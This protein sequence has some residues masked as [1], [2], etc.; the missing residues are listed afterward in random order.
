MLSL[1]GFAS[2]LV[3]NV[4]SQSGCTTTTDY[5]VQFVIDESGSVGPVNYDATVDFVQSMIQNDISDDTPVSVLSFGSK[6]G[7]EPSIGYEIIYRF[8][9]DQTSRNG[10]IDALENSQHE[11]N[12]TPTRT[13][14][15]GAL[16]EWEAAE[17]AGK[18]NNGERILFLITD[19]VPYPSDQTP[20]LQSIY[21]KI[22]EL[23]VRIIILGI[24]QF[25]IATIS[26]VAFR[27]EDIYQ[28]AGFQEAQFDQL[29][30]ELSV[31]SCPPDDGC[32]T[33][34]EY[35]VQIIMDES[36]SVGSDGFDLSVEFVKSLIEDDISATTPISV[37]S[38]GGGNNPDV[39]LI[40]R[41]DDDQTSRNAVL[42]ALDAVDHDAGST[43]TRTAMLTGIEEYKRAINAGD[44]N[45]GERLLFLMTDGV[46]YPSNT[47]DPCISTILDDLA[48]LNIRVII[49]GIGN[50]NVD[51]I[52]CLA[53][54]DDI[55]TTTGF[56]SEA[57]DALEKAIGETICP[58][59][60]E[61]IVSPP[62]PLS[63]QKAQQFCK[64]T[65]GT[66]LATIATDEDRL[67]AIA[68]LGEGE[69]AWIGL[70]THPEQTNW[71][72]RSGE[73][74]PSDSAY[75]CVDFWL[76]QLNENTALRP[77]CIGPTEQG[78]ECA[79]FK[80]TENGVDNDVPSEIELRFLCDN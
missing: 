12:L 32:V 45:N 20:C 28:I 70:Y 51:S 24:G 50:F 9:D 2:L 71:R 4:Y 48:D 55:I 52:A 17:N 68:I 61:P 40:Y 78:Y 37:Y 67:E 66:N 26:C 6:A 63:C 21:D 36:G 15:E 7:P 31:V 80:T 38:F 5:N 29:E 65:Y 35:N 53:D 79:N 73:E 1:L 19:G 3:I 54:D 39:E 30:S 33:T 8:S 10:V 56:T 57:F 77:R 75:K 34:T 27:D 42:A 44:L 69:E 62:D 60:D 74:C 76:Y 64:D 18:L 25:N 46:P 59:P 23:N 14:L 43:P 41:F 58:D 72:F 11:G 13:A 22:N 47:Q 49:L 16:D